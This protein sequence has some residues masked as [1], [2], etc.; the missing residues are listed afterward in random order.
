MKSIKASFTFRVLTQ[1]NG[2]H[3]FHT[4]QTIE[5]EL[6]KNTSTLET[7][8]SHIIYTVLIILPLVY[9]QYILVPFLVSQN[10]RAMSAHAV[11]TTS[12]KTANIT[13]V[14]QHYKSIYDVYKNMDQ[15]MKS[16]LLQTIHSMYLN[17][18]CTDPVSFATQTT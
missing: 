3:L 14:W 17:G 1:K 12:Y 4:L 13:N 18:I 9:I 7:L 15:V 6:I 10:S 8:L 5:R 11:G 16:L 2:Q